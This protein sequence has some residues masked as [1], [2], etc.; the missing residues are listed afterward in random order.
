MTHSY[1]SVRSCDFAYSHFPSERESENGS[2]RSPMSIVLRD[3]DDDD[4]DVDECR[5]VDGCPNYLL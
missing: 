5:A 4:G 2:P 1:A 3:D